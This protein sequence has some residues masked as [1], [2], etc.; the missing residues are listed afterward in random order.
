MTTT[1]ASIKKPK[2]D[3]THLRSQSEGWPE[4]P[5][6]PGEPRGARWHYGNCHYGGWS[7]CVTDAIRESAITVGSGDLAD[8]WRSG[9]L[10]RVWWKAA[11]CLHCANQ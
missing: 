3:R 10:I 9:L 1:C 11:Q 6:A 7:A 4:R 2:P 8:W 5:V